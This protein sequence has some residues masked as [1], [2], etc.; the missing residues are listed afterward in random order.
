VAEMADIF[1]KVSGTCQK[2]HSNIQDY[3]PEVKNASKAVRFGQ[4]SSERLSQIKK[5]LQFD[6]ADLNETLAQ[7]KEIFGG[8]T[9]NEIKPSNLNL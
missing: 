9:L 2:L 5:T 6:Q 3:V 4:I 7:L 8:D 1:Q